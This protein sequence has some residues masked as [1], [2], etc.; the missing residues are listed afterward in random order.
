MIITMDKQN[1]VSEK[2]AEKK[3]TKIIAGIVLVQ[4]DLF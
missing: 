2:K 1:F 3:Y 4:W